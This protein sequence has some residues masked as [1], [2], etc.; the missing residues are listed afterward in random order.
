MTTCISQVRLRLAV[1]AC[2][3]DFSATLCPM[4]AA[5]PSSDPTRGVAS[6]NA[7]D[8][9]VV[10]NCQVSYNLG[11]ISRMSFTLKRFLRTSSWGIPCT[12]PAIAKLTRA[13]NT[14]EQRKQI[15]RLRTRR[16]RA[17]NLED[18][19]GFCWRKG[20]AARDAAVGGCPRTGKLVACGA[21]ASTRVDGQSA[22]RLM[23]WS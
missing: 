17:R 4:Q 21:S 18:R 7:L 23:R 13:G 15:L 16:A 3:S 6:R 2:A 11:W 12:P 19:R 20:H 9:N 22:S 1:A 14:D 5:S 8:T 10:I